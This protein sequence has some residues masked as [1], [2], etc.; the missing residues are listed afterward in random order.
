MKPMIVMLMLPLLFGGCNASTPVPPQQ[1]GNAESKVTI[2]RTLKYDGI[3]V[4][5]E[6]ITSRIEKSPE[7]HRLFQ[8][9]EYKFHWNDGEFYF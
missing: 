7:G 2:T 5:A 9:G 8:I 4:S 1:T 3:S 6:G